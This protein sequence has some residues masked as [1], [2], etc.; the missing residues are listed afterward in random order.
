[1][2]VSSYLPIICYAGG[3]SIRSGHEKNEE[4]SKSTTL[5]EL[6]KQS[7][8]AALILETGVMPSGQNG[9]YQNPEAP[10]GNTAH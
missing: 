2:Q 6:L 7:A 9:P 3:Q 4:L 8:V 10:V 1:M 5:N